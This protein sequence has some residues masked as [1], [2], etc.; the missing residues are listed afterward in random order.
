MVFDKRYRP[1]TYNAFKLWKQF[2]NITNFRSFIFSKHKDFP[3]SSTQYFT[4]KFRR[5]AFK[6]E[7]SESKIAT[8]KSTILESKEDEDREVHDEESEENSMLLLEDKFMRF[9]NKVFWVDQL[10]KV[11]LLALFIHCNLSIF[12]WKVL[13][14]YTV[15]MYYFIPAVCI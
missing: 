5:N 3:L 14:G 1:E 13:N 8:D 4:N 10:F 6:E 12:K 9:Q 11:N 7:S 2:S 15:I